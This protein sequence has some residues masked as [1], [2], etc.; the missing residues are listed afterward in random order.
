MGVEKRTQNWIIVAV[1]LLVAI[2]YPVWKMYSGEPAIKQGI[3]LVG[4]VDLLLQAQVSPEQGKITPDMMVGAIDII[5]DRLD[6]E[7]IKEIVL[8]QLG[9]DRIIV[10]IPGEDDPERVKNLIG[11]TAILRFIDAGSDPIPAQTKLRF[12]DANT[13]EPIPIPGLEEQPVEEEALALTP[14]KVVLQGAGIM[15][16][17]LLPD[18]PV[19]DE[20]GNEVEVP[21]STAQG[22]VWLML[23]TTQ[24]VA[25]AVATSSNSG[26]WFSLIIDDHIVTSV[27][28]T[29]PLTQN[30]IG[31]PGL[32]DNP[33]FRMSELND[34]LDDI[35]KQIEDRGL[36]G[37]TADALQNRIKVVN[38]GEILP[39]DGTKVEV[40]DPFATAPGEEER[41]D[42]S[43]DR[44]ILTG[45]DFDDAWVG[46][47][48][49]T[50]APQID[51]KFKTRGSDPS[52]AEIFGRYTARNVGKYLAI[53]LDDTIISCPV[54]R[55]AILGGSGVITGQ[56]TSQEVSDLVIKLDSGRLPVPLQ[57][58]ENRTVGPTLGEKSI[59]DSKNAA[60]LGA[61][62][63]LLYMLLYYRLPGFISDIALIYYGIIF[64]GALSLMNATLTLP[65]IAGF[66]VSIGMAVDANVIIFERLKEELKSGKTF[67]SAVDAAHKRAFLAIFDSN[68][69]TLIT[70]M[71]LYNLGTGPIKGFAV[72]LSLGIV[73]SMFS[74]LVFTRL[75]LE[76][77]L[78]FK[79]A[80]SYGM[81]GVNKAD[82]SVG[83]KGGGR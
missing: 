67:R 81:Y 28:I 19:E 54:I 2:L 18:Q 46:F 11:R 79:F 31:F 49:A 34:Y 71:V 74:A 8:Q 75:L 48:N 3:D 83:G 73:V 1:V 9:E 26:D 68:I 51:F 52:P 40:I 53:A 24:G 63:V 35:A 42:I 59:N 14:D 30:R 43:T 38:A 15:A 25:L 33:A 70:A 17:G 69:T 47:D 7:G 12:I 13:G 27:Q 56:F 57:I 37:Q 20:V 4:G 16:F 72:T 55:S 77:F 58:I 5:R 45:D 6:P 60:I 78:N 44:V 29:Q 50:G 66:I 36:A 22:E 39:V 32:A 62:L 10:Q 61:I 76:S 65:G 82:V 64:M 41:M 80:Q 23:G 21:V